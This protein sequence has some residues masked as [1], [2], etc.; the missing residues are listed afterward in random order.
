MK[1]FM[2]VGSDST[3]NAE[4]R[5]TSPR[6]V[7]GGARRWVHAG[8][9]LIELMIVVAIIA[10]LAAIAYPSYTSYITRTHRWRRRGVCLK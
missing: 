3:S 5:E 9:T 10:I 8:F 2:P 4:C 6:T 1:R 7:F